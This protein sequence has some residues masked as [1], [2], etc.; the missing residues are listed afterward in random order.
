LASSHSASVQ[1]G[2]GRLAYA[3]DLEAATRGAAMLLRM[4]SAAK[5]G[6]C[7]RHPNLG[8]N[9]MLKRLILAVALMG[10]FGAVTLPNYTIAQTTTDDTKTKKKTTKKKEEKADTK[11]D[12]QKPKAAAKK[13]PSAKQ[14]AARKKFSDC[15]HSWGDHKKSTG[16]K[17]KKAYQAYMSTCL[18]KAN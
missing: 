15:A 16:E 12:D 13:A 8:G 17:G 6:V 3:A 1:G 2:H 10:F 7:F 11:A 5:T 14:L 9:S 18:K 4:F